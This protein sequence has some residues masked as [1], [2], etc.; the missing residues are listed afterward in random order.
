MIQMT[1]DGLEVGLRLDEARTRTERLRPLG[2]A[3]SFVTHQVRISST[4]DIDDE[5]VS[6]VKAA[7]GGACAA[8]QPQH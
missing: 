7:K 8:A 3:A 1:E 2:K 6:W 5:L 4:K